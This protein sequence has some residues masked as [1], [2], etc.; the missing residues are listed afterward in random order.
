[1]VRRGRWTGRRVQ[2]PEPPN[3]WRRWRLRARRAARVPFHS[4]GVGFRLQPSA[5]ASSQSMISSGVVGCCPAKARRFRIGWIDSLMFNQEPPRGVER[6]MIPCWISQ[7]TRLG[8]VW[9]A[10]LSPTTSLRRGGK[11][12]D[13]GG[14]WLSPT[15]QRSHN[16]RLV[17]GSSPAPGG[18]SSSKMALSSCFNQGGRTVFGQLV[19]PVTRTCPVEG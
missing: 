9:P 16:A 4:N 8:V 13:R 10:R 19:P 7:S 1:M 18:R 6:G 14:G 12:S 5:T 11:S 17:S 2:A 3:A 15:P